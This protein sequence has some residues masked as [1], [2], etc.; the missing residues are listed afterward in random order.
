MVNIGVLATF[1]PF[2]NNPKTIYIDV[3]FF[4]IIF[5]YVHIVIAYKK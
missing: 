3:L 2:I 4:P 5:V 1:I